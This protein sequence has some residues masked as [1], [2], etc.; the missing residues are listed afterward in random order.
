MW[1]IDYSLINLL[2]K[3]LNN[4]HTKK[5]L[6]YICFYFNGSD[7]W[8]VYYAIQSK[9]IILQKTLCAPIIIII[10]ILTILN[11]N[12][13]ALKKIAKNIN[14]GHQNHC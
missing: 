13:Y 10:L 4:K 7:K 11:Q 6:Q 9:L 12:S 8:H 2:Q 3:W 5:Y 14:P 1:L